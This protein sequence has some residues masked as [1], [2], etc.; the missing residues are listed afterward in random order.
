VDL[1]LADARGARL[2]R[3]ADIRSGVESAYIIQG[4][5]FDDLLERAARVDRKADRPAA[6]GQARDPFW[7]LRSKEKRRGRALLG[8]GLAGFGLGVRFVALTSAAH[9]WRVALIWPARPGVAPRAG[10]GSNLLDHLGRELATV[11]TTADA[12][13]YAELIAWAGNHAPGPRL[14]WAVEGSRS[15]GVGLLRALRRTGHTVVEAGRPRR[16]S[17]RPGGKSDPADARQAARDALAAP[18]RTE[19]RMD[20]SREALRIL[21]QARSQITTIRTATVNLFKALLLTAPDDLRESQRGLSTAAQTRR[22]TT[23]RA[24][25]TQSISEQTLRRELRRLARHIRALDV[26]L[27]ANHKQLRDLVGHTLPAL[28]DQPGV[29]PMSAAQLIV[30]WSHPGRLHSEAADF[31]TR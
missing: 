27:R 11:T 8:P 2:D 25:T 26:E 20:G 9:A 14:R 18:R 23:L 16:V 12:R 22:C 7:S 15:H 6:D 10:S 29:G 1:W 17:R 28:L 3:V 13:G 30:S 19:P 24:T 21:L 4:R 5:R 31:L